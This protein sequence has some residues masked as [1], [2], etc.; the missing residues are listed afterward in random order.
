MPYAR[1]SRACLAAVT[2]LAAVALVGCGGGSHDRKTGV[3]RTL[4]SLTGSTLAAARTAA[5]GAGFGNI[6]VSDATGAKR[7]VASPVE[8]RVCFQDPASGSADTGIRVRLSV[9]RLTEACPA[10][11]GGGSTSTSTH[12][13]TPSHKASKSRRTR[14]RTR[15]Q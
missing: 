5:S 1:T 12:R 7:P 6:G 14:N 13:S 10:R 15:R 3:T 4:P 2:A 11:D 8:W 9:A